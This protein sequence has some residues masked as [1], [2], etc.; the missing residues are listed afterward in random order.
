MKL[1]SPWWLATCALLVASCK[2]SDGGP[3]AP[4]AKKD[5]G[6]GAPTGGGKRMSG[7]PM[8]PGREPAHVALPNDND[9]HEPWPDI[10]PPRKLGGDALFEQPYRLY[11]C[12]LDGA[13]SD[14][15][16]NNRGDHACLV[17]IR[18]GKFMAGAQAKDPKGPNYDPEAKED[19]A[20]PHEVS[21][22]GFWIATAEVSYGEYRICV[23]AG[24]CDTKDV[25]VPGGDL[26]AFSM[27]RPTLP[28][29]GISWKGASDYCRWAG[30]RLPTEAEWEW[31]ARGSELRKYPWGDRAPSCDLTVMH[32]A[33][34][35]GCGEGA[36][37]YAYWGAVVQG[38]G[39]LTHARGPGDVVAI[40]N[41][42]GNVAE[43]V[44]DWYGPYPSTPQTA[45]R[46]RATGE[47]RVIR[48]GSFETE[49][50]ADLRSTARASWAPGDKLPDVG[51]RCAADKVF[52]RFPY[53]KVKETYLEEPPGKSRF[54][55]RWQLS[56]VDLLNAAGPNGQTM[57]DQLE[58]DSN[59]R[60]YLAMSVEGRISDD[61]R[62]RLM[63]A[64]IALYEGR[65]TEEE[66][67]GTA[68]SP[69]YGATQAFTMK[70]LR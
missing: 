27:E 39:T 26:M 52:G 21:L 46:G 5:G 66:C 58:V 28:V 69:Y 3:P 60:I 13:G 56:S 20:P 48:G 22:E 61:G 63:H 64:P 43:W 55:G 30:G 40:N 29:R 68:D 41:I 4:V 1:C 16:E 10:C 42:S 65:C 19:E 59:G 53:T 15:H 54:Q 50:F 12:D 47:E 45:P 8:D 51:V 25:I 2:C 34:G 38:P 23:R 44:Q 18:A 9:V 17:R 24:A 32:S 67:T 6:S 70:R 49:E 33:A 57:G 62:L 31:V 7:R 37:F 14:F 35:P 36:P 11:A